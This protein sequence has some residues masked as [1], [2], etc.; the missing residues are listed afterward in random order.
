MRHLPIALAVALVAAALPAPALAQD[1]QQPAHGRVT[2][3]LDIMRFKATKSGTVA[4]GKA[5]A[6]LRGLGGMPTTV[7]KRVTLS[8]KKSGSCRILKLVLDELDLTLLGLNVHLDKVDLRVTGRRQGGVLGRLFCS[9]AGAKVKAGRAQAVRALNTRI[10]HGGRIRPF[11]MTVPVQGVAAQAP[12]CPVLDL[13][14]GP[15]NL[16]L[17][18]LLVDLNKVHLTIVATPGGGSLGDLFCGLSK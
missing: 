2:V 17:L 16:D 10:R 5:T 11:R 15:L 13:V 7:T 18:G 12:T 1:E 3:K 6:R 9:I 14:V 4:V 8:A